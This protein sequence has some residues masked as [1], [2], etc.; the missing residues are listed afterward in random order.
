MK[1]SL[2]ATVLDAAEDIG[3]FLA[4]IAGQSARPTRS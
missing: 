3:G 2:I 4:S 1:V